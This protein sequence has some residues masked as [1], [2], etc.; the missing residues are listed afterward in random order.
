LDSLAYID[1][2][3]E[4]ERMTPFK[5]A[6]NHCSASIQNGVMVCIKP[7]YSTNDFTNVVNLLTFGK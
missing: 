2:N 5:Y 6:A 7:K 4:P 3:A 1:N